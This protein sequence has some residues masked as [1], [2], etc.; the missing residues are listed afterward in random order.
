M[1]S[2]IRQG[3]RQH[4]ELL[5]RELGQW[6]TS[7]DI[8]LTP[9]HQHIV[10]TLDWLDV[11][12]LLGYAGKRAGP[13]ER[14]RLALAQAFVAK[15]V[16]RLGQTKQLRERLVADS[17]LRRLLGFESSYKLPSEATF[18]R[19][20]KEF[21]QTG[22]PARVHEALIRAH[23]GNV[24]IG[25]IARDS[26][27]IHARERAVFMPKPAKVV[28]PRGRRPKDA[29]PEPAALPR[30]RIPAQLLQTPLQALADLPQDCNKGNKRD[31]HGS[32]NAWV[33]YKLHL[34]VACCGVPIAA[35]LTSASVHDNQASVPLAGLS[36]Q[37]VT[38]LYTL[39]D[40]AYDSEALREFERSLGHV[41]IIAIN[42]R[43]RLS[44]PTLDDAQ[45]KRFGERTAVERAYS[46]LKDSFAC[47]SVWV[48]GH[49]KVLCHAMFA[50]LAL[51]VDALM[52][53]MLFEHEPQVLAAP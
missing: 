17:A 33:G 5:Q 41:P 22:L 53:L 21:A 8:S 24:L 44:P 42:S 11:E 37:R 52:R 29:P 7:C 16:L 10:Q 2:T 20:F 45:L 32:I 26:T 35:A 34:D 47:D 49:A 9:K 31:A 14:S 43:G 19:A 1:N 13:P 48:K 23:L 51:S 3:Y 30:S 4:R 39:M 25:H 38:S 50:V 6:A 46:R 28:R 18:S 40:A 36:A 12:S 27:A 15:A